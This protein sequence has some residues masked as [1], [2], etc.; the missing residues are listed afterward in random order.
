MAKKS[1][2]IASRQAAVGKERKRKKKA[3]AGDKR[4][5]SYTTPA[6][7]AVSEVTEKTFTETVPEEVSAPAT[8]QPARTVSQEFDRYR[9]VIKDLRYIAI[10]AGPLLVLLIILA[11]VL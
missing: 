3:Q 5:V 6:P 8:A 2:R 11:L 7:P 10:I 1:H 4:T 9:Y